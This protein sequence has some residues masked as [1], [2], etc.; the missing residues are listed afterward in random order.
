M[1]KATCKVVFTSVAACLFPLLICLIPVASC[2]ATSDIMFG[3]TNDD[4]RVSVADADLLLHHIAGLTSLEADQIGRANVSAS[5][6]AAG[7]HTL[8]VGDAIAILR[9]ITGLIEDF[10]AQ[11]AAFFTHFSLGLPGETVQLDLEER[12]V[13]LMVPY[14]E[15]TMAQKTSFFGLPYGAS[16][17]VEGVIQVSGTAHLDFR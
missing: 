17:S 10:P 4:G 11:S 2:T 16:A 5:Y 12:T 3:D 15:G 14:S 7:N 6:D 1:P 9:H 13:S 8:A